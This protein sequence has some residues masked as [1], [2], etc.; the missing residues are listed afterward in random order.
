[1]ITRYHFIKEYNI[2]LISQCM[3][4][5]DDNN[6]GLLSSRP[7]SQVVMMVSLLCRS[8]LFGLGGGPAAQAVY[9]WYDAICRLFADRQ[10][11]ERGHVIFA[12]V[13]T[14]IAF[15]NPFWCIS[16][17]HGNQWDWIQ[18]HLLWASHLPMSILRSSTAKIK[19]I[20][21]PQPYWES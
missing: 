4:L 11:I 19:W 18:P 7:R 10:Q 13:C 15:A 17:S 5:T 20:R 8:I 1:M 12:I 14:L 21:V 3:E 16:L 6:N 2:M 9:G